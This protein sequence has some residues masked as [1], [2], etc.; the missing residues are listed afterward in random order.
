MAQARTHENMLT[1]PM[2]SVLAT[3]ASTALPPARIAST[4]MSEQILFSLA[5][6][7][8]RASIR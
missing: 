7:P 4:P 2:Q 5:T 8:W 3:A 6:A 1:T